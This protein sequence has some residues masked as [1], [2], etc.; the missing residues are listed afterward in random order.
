MVNN[1]FLKRGILFGISLFIFVFSFGQKN[2]DKY[3]VRK[4]D[5]G[6]LYFVKPFSALRAENSGRVEFDM[7]YLN[8]KDSITLNFYF[9][10][11]KLE[12]I[13]VLAFVTE[14]DTLL[15]VPV[16]LLFA[17]KLKK[18][19]RFRGNTSFLYSK[20][21]QILNQSKTVKLVLISDS[22]SPYL[23]RFNNWEKY[24]QFW[25]ELASLISIN[26]NN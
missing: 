14:A 17:D 15:K 1:P 22:N 5:G 6:L 12:N 4:V 8:V 19:F 9:I 7:T 23:F 10:N 2:S 24:R 11:K 3:L 18:N 20:W 21:L 16:S 25:L 13:K 26:K